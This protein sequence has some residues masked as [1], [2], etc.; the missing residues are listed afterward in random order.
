MLKLK[1]LAPKGYRT[2]RGFHGVQFLGPDYWW[3]YDDKK[4][5]HENEIKGA[6]SNTAPCRTVKG[7]QRMLRKNPTI[8]GKSVLMH[9]EYITG[10]NGK[11]LHSLNVESNHDH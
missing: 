6:Y 1:Y 7:F 11:F 8:I 3:S 2:N 9:R 4:W 10:D 5:M